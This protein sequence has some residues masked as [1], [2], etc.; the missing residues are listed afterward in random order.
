MLVRNDPYANM[1]PRDFLY[2]V[3]RNIRLFYPEPA[4]LKTSGHVPSRE[5]L[6]S[7][8]VRWK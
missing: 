3:D 6:D 4:L 1:S 8:T 7:L 5:F 2:L